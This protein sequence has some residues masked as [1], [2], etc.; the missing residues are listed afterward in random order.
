LE[1]TE[2]SISGSGDIS[3]TVE[4]NSFSHIGL[5]DTSEGAE[6][7]RTEGTLTEGTEP[8]Y[9]RGASGSVE[10]V[11]SQGWDSSGSSN[12][13]WSGSGGIAFVPR[14]PG[15]SGL[16]IWVGAGSR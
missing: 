12:G 7:C 8:G 14:I 9:A 1:T 5:F 10:C 13:T 15:T 6:A 11:D 3:G 16:P 4:G 2:T